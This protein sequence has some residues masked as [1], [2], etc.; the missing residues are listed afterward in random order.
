M[1]LVLHAWL[2][3]PREIELYQDSNL[4]PPANLTYGNYVSYVAFGFKF[5]PVDGVSVEIG[6]L[7]NI[8]DPD[9]TAD[10]AFLLNVSWRY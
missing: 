4:V 3:T 7:E 1:S 2:E 6:A 5:S 9:V 8:I 10:L